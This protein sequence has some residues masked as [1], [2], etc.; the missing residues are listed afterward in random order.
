MNIPSGSFSR[1]SRGEILGEVFDFDEPL[2]DPPLALAPEVEDLDPLVVVAPGICSWTLGLLDTDSAVGL[3]PYYKTNIDNI[4]VV[5]IVI[6]S[7]CIF[8]LLL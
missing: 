6:V 7:Y 5:V 4:I 8:F 3:G 2:L 1:D